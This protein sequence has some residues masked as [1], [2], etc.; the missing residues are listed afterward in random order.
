M[1]KV[2]HTNQHR[3]NILSAPVFA[4]GNTQW[5]GDGY[6][7]WQ[8]LEF[9]EEWGYNRI[10]NGEEYKKGIYNKFD[11]Y[12]AEID[13]DFPSEYTIDSVFNE[14]DYYGFL[15]IVED[16]A[17]LYFKNHG[18]WPDLGKFNDFIAGYDL[19]K[20]TV[21][22]RF[23]DLPLKNERPYLKVK[24]FYYKKRIQIVL[25]DVYKIHKFTHYKTL[26][27]K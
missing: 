22:I 20:D 3:G 23:Q 2:Y 12:E 14:E 5:L 27:C 17:T 10:C 1:I 21:A 19:W 8:D 16:F 9:A 15:S 4:T 6:Y 13:I 11:I 7:F 26:D 18:D 25:Y 24:K